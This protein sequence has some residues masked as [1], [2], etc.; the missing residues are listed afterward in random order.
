MCAEFGAIPVENVWGAY[1][2][3]RVIATQN[4]AATVSFFLER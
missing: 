1:F 4:G 2:V 3:S